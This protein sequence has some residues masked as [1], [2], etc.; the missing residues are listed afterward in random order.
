M[1][2]QEDALANMGLGKVTTCNIS[3]EG[4]KSSGIDLLIQM[5]QG[6]DDRSKYVFRERVKKK[7]MKAQ[8]IGV[9]TFK[10]D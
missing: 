2:L 9:S 4:I 3:Y 1:N 5:N 7:M 6:T 8:V 10:M